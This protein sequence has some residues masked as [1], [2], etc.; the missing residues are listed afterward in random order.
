M[1]SSQVL[2]MDRETW[3]PFDPHDLVQAL[4]GA[5]ARYIDALSTCSRIRWGASASVGYFQEEEQAAGLP[6]EWFW[7]EDLATSAQVGGTV[8][9]IDFQ[10]R[11]G[12]V[13]AYRLERALELELRLD[14]V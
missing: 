8:F 2:E 13:R 14:D 11:D 4:S 3:I 1:T 7:D 6:G 9:V 12:E 5:G 10:T